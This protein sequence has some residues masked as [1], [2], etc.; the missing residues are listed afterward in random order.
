MLSQTAARPGKRTISYHY[1][2]TKKLLCRHANDPMRRSSQHGTLRQQ[3]RRSLASA[4]PPK[5]TANAPI[6]I[7][8]PGPT[9]SLPPRCRPES[10]PSRTPFAEFD[11]SPTLAIPL[12]RGLADSDSG[13]RRLQDNRPITSQN[14]P[15]PPKLT[16]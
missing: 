6:Q 10:F 2:Q 11:E 5:G 8:R 9:V 7:C 15:C 13:L 4:D 12:L 3:S 16:M 1:R 14:D